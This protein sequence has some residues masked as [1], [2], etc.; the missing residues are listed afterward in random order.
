MYSIHIT[1]QTRFV[2]NKK[3]LAQIIKSTIMDKQ[4][5]YLWANKIKFI[6]DNSSSLYIWSNP[7]T[8]EQ[9]WLINSVKLRLFDQLGS[10][11]NYRII[12][13]ELEIEKYLLKIPR[14]FYMPILKYRTTN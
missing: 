5:C 6:L 14:K 7:I 1:A 9:T 8:I 13:T 12:K 10:Y 4:K 2:L 11:V 3:K